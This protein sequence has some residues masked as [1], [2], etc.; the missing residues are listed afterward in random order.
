MFP[1]R[2]IA[3]PGGSPTGTPDALAA[4]RTWEDYSASEAGHAAAEQARR[5]P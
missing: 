4:E 3:T 1:G 5:Q 2:N